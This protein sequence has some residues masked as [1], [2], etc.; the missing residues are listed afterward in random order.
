MASGVL[1]PV[2]CR[3][4]YT[5][6]LTVWKVSVEIMRTLPKDPVILLSTINMKLRDFYDSLDALCEDLEVD[7]K[8]LT[9]TLQSIDY[10]YDASEN[11]F[12]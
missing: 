10:H 7:C 1:H 12:K 6:V 8:Q 4:R 2:S 5:C 3:S 9:Q 11:Q